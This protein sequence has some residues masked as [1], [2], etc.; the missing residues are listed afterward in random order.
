MECLQ[1]IAEVNQLAFYSTDSDGNCFYDAVRQN[2]MQLGITQTIEEL[3][4]VTA[5]QLELASEIFS[6]LY[7][8]EDDN[9][10]QAATFKLF[11][12]RSTL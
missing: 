3:R 11:V 1:N 5:S 6:P 4:A 9:G 2:L 8:V 12:E 7:F 10:Q